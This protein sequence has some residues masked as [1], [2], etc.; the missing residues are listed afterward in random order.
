M[1]FSYTLFA[2]SES[3]LERRA[4]ATLLALQSSPADF[5]QVLSLLEDPDELTRRTLL[6]YLGAVELDSQEAGQLRVAELYTSARDDSALRVRQ[7]ALEALAGLDS[8][9]AAN[10]LFSLFGELSVSERKNA[11][12]LFC[13]V[14]Y[15]ESEAA[16]E[17][18]EEGVVA[19]FCES[20]NALPLDV[21]ALLL[22]NYGLRLA[23]R[24]DGGELARERAP[25][26]LGLRN[27]S[28]AIRAAA[29]LAFRMFQSRLRE[30]ER[31]ERADRSLEHFAT[32]G[33]P[34][35]P[36]LYLRVVNSMEEGTIE[37]DVALAGAR[38]L[39]QSSPADDAT[40]EGEWRARAA[41]LEANVLMAQ[42]RLEEAAGPLERAGDLYD[43]L[44]ARQLEQ[45]GERGAMRQ[46]DLLQGRALV[47]FAEVFRR[48]ASGINPNDLGLFQRLRTAHAMQIE[49]QVIARDS[50]VPAVA[51][52]DPFFGAALSPCAL[53]FAA[54]P[55]AAWD[56][57]RCIKMKRGLGRA[58]ASVSA[59]EMPGYEPYPYPLPE[60]GDP[61]ID[62][63]R[64]R[65]LDKLAEGEVR[66]L[67]R[68][69][70]VLR[71]K[72]ERQVDPDPQLESDIA[73][74]SYSLARTERSLK[75]ETLA[76]RY[77]GLRRPT[78]DALLL[79]ELLRREGRTEESRELAKRFDDDLTAHNLRQKFTWALHLAAQAELMIGGCWSDE[80]DA[81]SA[82]EH[83]LVALDLLE[84]LR[85]Y[86]EDADAP[87]S[88]LAVDN[89]IAEA[90]VSL[91]VNSNVKAKD[92]EKA[93][94]YFER[95]Y[96]LR[97]DDFM[98]IMLA[99]YRARSGR[100][101]EAREL[102]SDVPESPRGYYNLACTYALLGEVQMAL[103]YLERDFEENRTSREALEKQKEWA[104]GDPD[105]VALR[106]DPGFQF[107]TAPG[108]V[109]E[110]EEEK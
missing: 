32:D 14:M 53:I 36:L 73:F 28:P 57:A 110:S 27:P 90:L 61:V 20:P 56:A 75:R 35:K 66:A 25:L 76:D 103:E 107:L 87:D 7:A 5:E 41:L 33:V 49:S 40:E 24:E 6:E 104:R 12:E 16:R 92:P 54:K 10:A 62:I 46:R 9:L 80:G 97:Q 22:P 68:E 95:A 47:E 108:P 72:E 109:E 81:T 19:S 43:G 58:L 74:V 1:A 4:T 8:K 99:C 101:N 79:A 77:F 51:V 39:G 45:W 31:H 70:D 37:L 105:L 106:E 26:V 38:R 18:L 96:L 55:H 42:N 2:Q 44:I 102:I 11:A 34:T 59:R 84:G 48:I 63:R 15:P 100:A 29:D 65:W 52:M 89:E 23:E 88:A 69:L 64:R 98:R 91:A 93:L 17:L 60:V 94:A 82:E 3:L 50:D 78:A 30:L 86:F 13:S 71:S 21:L 85:T 67:K 83:M